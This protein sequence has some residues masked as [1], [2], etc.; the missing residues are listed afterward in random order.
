MCKSGEMK[1]MILFAKRKEIQME[2]T[3]V[4][5]RVHV[6]V[7][8]CSV[9]SDSLWPPQTVAHQVPLSMG[10]P[11]QKYWSGSLCSPL[12][13]VPTQGSNLHLLRLLHWPADS[14]P[15]HHCHFG[16]PKCK[17]EPACLNAS[18]VTWVVS[19]SL[20]PSGL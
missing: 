20:R 15:P 13:L 1:Q 19:D 12:G 16:S 5:I 4:W 6:C 14:L 8:L 10:F 11:K 18:S 9:M 3:N 7:C 17:A 2:R